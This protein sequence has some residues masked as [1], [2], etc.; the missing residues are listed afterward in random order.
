MTALAGAATD[1]APRPEWQAAL[2]AFAPPSSQVSSLR[3]L[4][5]PGDP[6]SRVDRWMIWQVW[7]EGRLPRLIDIKG[8]NGPGPRSSGHACVPGGC[9][10]E[11]KAGHW[12]DGPSECHGIMH[13]Q[14]Q[15]WHEAGAYHRRWHTPYWVVQGPHG[16]H[17]YK[18][19]FI[20]SSVRRMFGQPADTPAPGDLPY[21]EPDQRT[22][23]SIAAMDITR[24]PIDL[25]QRQR[26]DQWAAADRANAEAATERLMRLLSDQLEGPADQVYSALR[27]DTDIVRPAPWD[28]RAPVEEEAVARAMRAAHPHYT[29]PAT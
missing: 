12:V 24:R 4:W 22:W 6:W 1:R 27:R 5:E 25:L 9:P 23:A 16:G 28:Q 15:L 18:L 29:T 21:A 11:H 20:E 13:R 2:D 8:L 19:D 3:I 7:P 17:R 26:P 14:W 10:C